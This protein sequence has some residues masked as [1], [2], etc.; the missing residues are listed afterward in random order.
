MV[1]RGG[2][3]ISVVMYFCLIVLA[4]YIRAAI[5]TLQTSFA[6][7]AGQ[8]KMGA[9]LWGCAWEPYLSLLILTES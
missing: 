7:R 9:P 4:E 8:P 6:R 5:P 1:F 3:A 2:R